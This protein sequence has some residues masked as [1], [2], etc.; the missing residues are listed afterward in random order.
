MLDRILNY[1]GKKAVF[2]ESSGTTDGWDWFKYSDGT[3]KCFKKT[4]K[5]LN[6]TRDRVSIGYS[7]DSI[8]ENYP[9]SFAKEP[10]VNIAANYP[11]TGYVGY[12]IPGIYSVTF[13]LSNSALVENYDTPIWIA[14]EGIFR[15]GGVI[16]R[17]IT[18]LLSPRKVVE[19]C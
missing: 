19:V 10:I 15:V 16:A 9:F 5:K 12:V 4:V 8:I 7:A 13:S 2:L 14:V 3:A 17:L 18:Q 11:F 1:I 6:F